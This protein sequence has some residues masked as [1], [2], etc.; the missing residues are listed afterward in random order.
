MITSLLEAAFEQG[1]IKDA[2][3]SMSETQRT[4]LWA[5]RE[6]MSEAQKIEG[7]S[8]KHDVSV[9]VA[10]IPAFI[11]AANQVVE[12]V[13]PGARPVPFGHFGDGNIHYNITQPSGMDKAVFLAEWERL[14]RAV[15][16]V[17]LSFGGSISAEHGI[18]VMKRDLLLEVADPVKL[19]LMRQL[20]A[21]LDPKGIM[22]PGK[23][24]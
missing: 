22:N 16:E 2:I 8:I 14:N 19:K 18:G 5:L 13:V 24:I 10:S 4:E 12:E 23:M 6:M 9:P 20:K 1:M 21:T 17:V 11:A 15:Y 7:G 3:V